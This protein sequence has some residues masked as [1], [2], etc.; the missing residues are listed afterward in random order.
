MRSLGGRPSGAGPDFGAAYGAQAAEI[1]LDAIARSDG[2]RASVTREVFRT[3]VSDGILGNIRF[4][5]NGDLVDSPFTFVRMVDDPSG[6]ER[7]RPALDR[8]V[9][10]RS[11]LLRGPR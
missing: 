8:V 6:E 11:E 3:R 10:A 4:D 1:L 2:T 5:R 7:L 9:L